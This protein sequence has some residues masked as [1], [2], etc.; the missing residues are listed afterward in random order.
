M[1]WSVV[2]AGER[3]VALKGEVLIMSDAA[4][5]HEPTGP[6]GLP[7]DMTDEELEQ[8]PVLESVD[9]LLI[10]DLTDEEADAFFAAIDS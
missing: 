4:R 6:A 2:A 3:P 10:D 5:H 7:R 1:A 8:A 9:D